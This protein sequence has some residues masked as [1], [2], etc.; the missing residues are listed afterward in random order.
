MLSLLIRIIQIYNFVL[1]ADFHAYFF[2]FAT[3]GG[4]AQVSVI[5]PMQQVHALVAHH[6]LE[7]NYAP[8]RKKQRKEDKNANGLHQR[9]D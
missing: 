8:H 5:N 1:V 7:Q 9:P 3:M 2:I 6:S 4:T